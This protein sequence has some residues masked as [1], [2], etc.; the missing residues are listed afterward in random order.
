MFAVL[1]NINK[2]ISGGKLGVVD[3]TPDNGN[4]LVNVTV[5]QDGSVDTSVTGPAMTP[6]ND[7]LP[8]PAPLN[9]FNAGAAFG[10]YR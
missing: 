7:P 4:P 1:D 10:G 9:G 5:K 6:Y 3:N 8:T 2:Q